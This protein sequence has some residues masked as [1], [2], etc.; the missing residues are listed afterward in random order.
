MTGV[1]YVTPGDAARERA[2]AATRSALAAWKS[3]S[4]GKF[5]YHVVDVQTDA[6]RKA[7]LAAGSSESASGLRAPLVFT[8]GKTTSPVLLPGDSLTGLEYV[9]LVH[10]R[11]LVMREEH[12]FDRFGVLTGHDEIKL[13]DANLVP[14]TFGSPS[15]HEVLTKN[16]PQLRIEPVDLRHEDHASTDAMAGLLVTQPAT[17]LTEAELRRIDELILAGKPVVIIAS[18]VNVKAADPTMKATLGAHGLDKLLAGYGITMHADAVVD[19]DASFVSFSATASAVE[20]LPFPP[21]PLVSDAPGAD[22][23]RGLESGFPA[24]VGITT[25]AMPFASSLALDPSKQPE[26]TL[27]VLARS[28]ARTALEHGRTVDLGLKRVWKRPSALARA[29]LAVVV[30]GTLRS[31]FDPAQR[32]KQPGRI[33]LFASSQLLANPFARAAAAPGT[34]MGMPSATSA[35]ALANIA[36]PYAQQQLTALVL[37]AK[38]SFDWMALG[39]DERSCSTVESH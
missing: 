31:A 29:N 36:Q 34:A 9:M 11:G 18:A 12:R 22:G 23:Q 39:A 13:T 33:L 2:N 3:V 37:A 17:E 38:G 8:Y 10:A 21:V 1:L 15:V 5:D 27:R 16:F 26:A 25:L 7:A 32:S 4:G 24:F 35:D 30:E 19:L 28:S 20:K 14:R 6:D